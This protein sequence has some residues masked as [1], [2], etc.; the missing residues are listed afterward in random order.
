MSL[1]CK[2]KL[3]GTEFEADCDEWE[4]ISSEDREDGMGPKISYQM[5]IVGI[6]PNEQCTNR[7][8]AIDLF[9]HIDNELDPPTHD[10]QSQNIERIDGWCENNLLKERAIDFLKQE[11]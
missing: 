10:F 2:C 1:Q 11:E 5:T 8:Y 3:C 9:D 6:C 4:L 7:T